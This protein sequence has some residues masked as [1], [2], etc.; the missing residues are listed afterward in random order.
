VRSLKDQL[1]GR[2][3][4]TVAEIGGHDTWQSCTLLVAIVGGPDT[5]D[6]ADE[7]QRFIESRAPATFDRH[8]LTLDD[9]RA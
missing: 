1:R 2:F 3:G 8:L 5:S 9:L 4:A 6:R 7:L